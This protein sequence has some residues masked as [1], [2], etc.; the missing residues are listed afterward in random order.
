MKKPP[1]GAN[2]YRFSEPAAEPCLTERERGH[3]VAKLQTGTSLQK[4][5]KS[6]VNCVADLLLRFRVGSCTII[7]LME[8]P[9]RPRQWGSNQ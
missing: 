5:H 2:S 9:L 8:K 3:K 1:G 7:S 4:S 6:K